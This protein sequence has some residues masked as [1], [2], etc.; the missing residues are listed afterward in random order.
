MINNL[1]KKNEEIENFQN[2][3]YEKDKIIDE[4]NGKLKDQEIKIAEINQKLIEHFNN[5]KNTNNIILEKDVAIKDLNKKLK[6][7]DTTDIENINNIRNYINEINNYSNEKY[8]ELMNLICILSYNDF[9]KKINYKFDKDPQ[10]L[11]FKFNIN[12][13]NASYV[14]TM[15]LK[16]IHL[17]EI[18]ENI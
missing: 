8:K 9:I 14:G 5:L 2:L 4:I 6:N 7:K 13:T 17:V 18:I 15:Y 16:Y 3:I 1:N 11:T 12:N 10:N